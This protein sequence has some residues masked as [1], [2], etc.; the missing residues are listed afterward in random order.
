[1]NSFSRS[2]LAL[3]E[4]HCTEIPASRRNDLKSFCEKP[5]RLMS[6]ITQRTLQ[7]LMLSH[8]QN[9]PFTHSRP[10]LHEFMKCKRED[11]DSRL[12]ETK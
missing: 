6:V 5:G 7:Q 1:M 12:G 10:M 9:L 3:H 8:F 4:S 11:R 2:S